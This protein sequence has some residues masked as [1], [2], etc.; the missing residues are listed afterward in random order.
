MMMTMTTMA[1]R[2]S[3]GPHG[4]VM[5]TP[6][7][8]PA[9]A[10]EGHDR[11]GRNGGNPVVACAPPDEATARKGRE[12]QMARHRIYWAG[13]GYIIG[14]HCHKFHHNPEDCRG[15]CENPKLYCTCGASGDDIEEIPQVQ[16]IPGLLRA[17]R[18]RKC[19][20][21]ENDYMTEE[22]IYAHR[23]ERDEA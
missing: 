11:L 13:D 7:A 22:E 17:W 15:C 2:Q 12:R 6:V 4:P 9:N 23:A 10:R 16:R 5:R 1:I 8:S 21:H 3:Q 20:Q 19:G 18:C 14:G